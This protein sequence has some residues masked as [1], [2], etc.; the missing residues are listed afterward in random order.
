L[1]PGLIVQATIN[2]TFIWL[3]VCR[4]S[5]K[6]GSQHLMIANHTYGAQLLAN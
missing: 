6:S 5:V 2:G 3:L 1:I 4:T